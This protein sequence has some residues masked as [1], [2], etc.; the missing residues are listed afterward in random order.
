[1]TL[2]EIEQAICALPTAIVSQLR[3]AATESAC[4]VCAVWPYNENGS[5]RETSPVFRWHLAWDTAV[6][7]QKVQEARCLVIY[8][9]ARHRLAEA[10]AVRGG[11]G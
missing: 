4:G 10:A 6:D 8:A 2:D 3:P 11:G 7:F 9:I 1:M 5:P